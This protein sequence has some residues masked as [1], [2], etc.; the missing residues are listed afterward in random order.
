MEG[1]EEDRPFLPD[2]YVPTGHTVRHYMTIR[3]VS[4]EYLSHA[5]GEADNDFLD[6]L[7][8]GDAPVGPNTARILWSVFGV[9]SEFWLRRDERYWTDRRRIESADTMEVK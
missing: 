5:M 4:K 3:G 1:V 7:L 9:P 6:A 2:W 8:D